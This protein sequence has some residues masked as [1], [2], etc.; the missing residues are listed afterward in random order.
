MCQA[1][2]EIMEPE[3]MKIKEETRQRTRQETI[4]RAVEG[5]R[6]L[7]ADEDRIKEI[8]KKKYGFSDE[9]AEAYL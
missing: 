5:F 8:L 9:E 4:L 7:G 2:L 6:D 3:I 1:L